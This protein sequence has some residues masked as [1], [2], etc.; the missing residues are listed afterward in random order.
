MDRRQLSLRSLILVGN[1]VLLRSRAA[2]MGQS[3]NITICAP[4][5][6]AGSFDTARLCLSGGADATGAPDALCLLTRRP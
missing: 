2:L 6:A 1:P 3:I 4:D 5:E